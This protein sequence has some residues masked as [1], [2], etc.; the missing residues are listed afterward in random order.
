[1][2]GDGMIPIDGLFTS[3][4]VAE[5]VWD[6]NAHKLIKHGRMVKVTVNDQGVTEQPLRPGD[7][8]RV[9]NTRFRYEAPSPEEI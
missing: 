2:G 6:G 4:V 8:I 1:M 9:G 3:G 7:R 5:L